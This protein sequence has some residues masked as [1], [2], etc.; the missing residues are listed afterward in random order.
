[1]KRRKYT[2][3]EREAMAQDLGRD[4]GCECE[5][6]GFP[7]PN[8]Q[9]YND[10]HW[11]PKRQVKCDLL[12]HRRLLCHGFDRKDGKGCHDWVENHPAAAREE[13]WLAPKYERPSC[14]V[15]EEPCKEEG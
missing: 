12:K 15:C 14:D 10:H 13:G 2:I 9:F 5:R 6:C 1:M 3:V 4:R 11:F 7:L 8:P